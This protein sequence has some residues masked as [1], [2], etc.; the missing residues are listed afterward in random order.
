M[1]IDPKNLI[2][3]NL[4]ITE[5]LVKKDPKAF[6]DYLKEAIKEIES[7]ESLK[8]TEGEKIKYLTERL[9]FSLD[10]LDKVAKTPLNFATSQ[11]LADFFLTQAF[12]MEKIAETLPDGALKNLFLESAI[13]LG[14]EGEKIKQGF[15]QA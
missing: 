10:L 4:I 3:P 7:L 1:K 9:E 6:E 13:Y 14:V 5:I 2:D 12:E 15:Y 11:T 8:Q